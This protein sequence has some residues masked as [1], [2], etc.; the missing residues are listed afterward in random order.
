MIF[1]EILDKSIRIY[2]VVRN[3]LAKKPC[4]HPMSYRYWGDEARTIHHC[5]N[6]GEKNIKVGYDS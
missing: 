1:K 2:R 6:C 4:S 3:E 5:A